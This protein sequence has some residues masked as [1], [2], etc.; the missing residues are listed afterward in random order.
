M[1][2]DEEV[3]FLTRG[4]GADVGRRLTEVGWLAVMCTGN[5]GLTMVEDAGNQHNLSGKSG[6]DEVNKIKPA[7]LFDPSQVEK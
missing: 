4:G 1:G 2:R 7:D 3:V 6:Q 5:G